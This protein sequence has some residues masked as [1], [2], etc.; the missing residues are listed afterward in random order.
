[1]LLR[2]GLFVQLTIERLAVGK[3]LLP[4][5]C[6]QSGEPCSRLQER[7]SPAPAQT[8]ELPRSLFSWTRHLGHQHIML[9]ENADGSDCRKKFVFGPVVLRLSEG[10]PVK[11]AP[12]RALCFRLA[13]NQ[14]YR[15]A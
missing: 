11:S 6:P 7:S 8:R 15:L 4:P 3:P 1:M 13:T 14:S 2:A 10:A 5:D 12:P 9:P